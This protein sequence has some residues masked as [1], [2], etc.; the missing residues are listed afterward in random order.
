MIRLLTTTFLLTCLPSKSTN[1]FL[2]KTTEDYLTK[3]GYLPQSDLETGAQRTEQQLT[4]AVRNLQ[5]FAGLNVTGNLDQ[6]TLQLMTKPRCG[7]PDVT[8]NGYRNRRTI[9][10]KRYNLQGQRW[11]R[12]S[13]KWN[14]RT[15]PEDTNMDKNSV[16]WVLATALS[17][18]AKQT[19]L[20]FTEVGPTDKTSD[21]QGLQF[22]D[23][24]KR[25]Q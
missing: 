24:A 8:Y 1:L 25:G 16:R 18:W 10:V 23:C 5:F 13:L 4:D 19:G 14:L 15:F 7:V 6:N 17:L 9:R 22:K 20:T 11:S 2:G 21:L 3:Y 12:T